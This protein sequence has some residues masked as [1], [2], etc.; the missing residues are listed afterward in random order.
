M[1]RL[2]HF[3][4]ELIFDYV[5]R[6]ENRGSRRQI[7]MVAHQHLL[8]VGA[9]KALM[10]ATVLTAARI[11][12]WLTSGPPATAL[13]DKAVASIWDLLASAIGW[14]VVFAWLG[15]SVRMARAY[16]YEPNLD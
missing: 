7:G 2:D 8:N 14:L 9:V 12:L 11:V 15:V 5:T 3:V 10:A 16:L 13:L 1:K 6:E 4:A